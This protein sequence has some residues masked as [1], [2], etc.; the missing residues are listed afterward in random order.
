[1]NEGSQA[2]I[3]VIDDNDRVRDAMCSRIRLSS[4]GYR[5][6]GVRSGGEALV[7]LAAADYD[8]VLCDLV[9]PGGEDGAE[10]TRQIRE[11]H[12]GVRVVVFSGYETGDRKGQVLQAGAFAYLAKPIDH[13]ELLH[14]IKT[15]DGVRRTER[16]G[17]AFRTLAGISHELQSSFDFDVLAERVVAG[18]RR[19][20]YARARLYLYDAERDVLVGKVASGMA[21]DDGFPGYEVPLA[22]YPVIKAIFEARRPT[23]WNEERLVEK[24][25]TDP[26]EPWLTRL[27]LEGLTWIDL[28][29]LVGHDRVGTLA[30]DHGADHGAGPSV[31]AR[32]TAAEDLEILDVFAGLAAQA[33]SNAQIYEKEALA[34]AS[35]SSILRDAPDGVVT[36]DLDGDVTFVS[37]SAE[38]LL[39]QPAEK[40]LGQPAHRFYTDAEGTPDAGREIARGIMA[41]LRAEGTISNLRVDLLSPK[42]PRPASISISLLHD[43]AGASIGTLAIVKELGALDSQSEQYRD[44]LEGFGY[45][46]LILS[47]RGNVQFINKKALRL[48]RRSRDETLGQRFA[49]MVLEAQR[50]E[51]EA[52]FE[53]VL[54]DG[55]EAGLELSLLRGDAHRVAVSTRLTPVRSRRRRSGVAVALYDKGELGAL[56]QSGRLMALGQM[57]AGVAHEINN[58]LNNLLVASRELENRLRRVGALDEK[59]GRYAEM[60]E[61]N[62]GRIGGIIRQ[63]RDFAR[64]SGF[65]SVP[66]DLNAVVDEALDFFRTRFRHHDIELRVELADGLPR[67]SGDAHRLQ[68]V[69][70]NLIVNAEDAMKEQSEPRFLRVVTRRAVP[71]GAEAPRVE[72]QI[73][74]NGCGIPEEILE[75]IFD[76]FFTTKAPNQGTGLGL[77]ISKS[78]LDLHDGEIR[79]AKGEQGRGARF[80][81]SFPI[82][83]G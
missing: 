75:A 78:I 28:P 61:R 68:Q 39:G 4:E 52:G 55:G 41:R 60:I 57:V 21:D 67:I 47:K 25:G 77:S 82:L 80:T 43:D 14:T 27:E 23:V 72:V 20:G 66:V 24:F 42:G 11:R 31:A 62:A 18:A 15:I 73:T 63:L 30:V 56:I 6:D 10:I 16:L 69:L 76:P 58:P 3:L 74:D 49:D 45:G 8:V 34:N 19:L 44:V 32:R 9:L 13:E 5:V 2:R 35:L 1:M 64:P 65:E 70:V 22:A 51:F 36:T 83:Q 12:P 26:K 71:H 33:L 7:C 79:V 59:S 37:P 50:H 17:D 40:I 38:E 48:L 46:T 29:L 54:R 81:L 53:A